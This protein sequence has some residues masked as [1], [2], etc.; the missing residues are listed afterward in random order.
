M[1][2]T[3]RYLISATP[4]PGSSLACVCFSITCLRSDLYMEIEL[5][6]QPLKSH[7][8]SMPQGS[9][10]P[11]K[12]ACESISTGFA[13]QSTNLTCFFQ[14]LLNSQKNKSWEAG[15]RQNWATNN[16]KCS[17][18]SNKLDQNTSNLI[19]SHSNHYR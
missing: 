12:K 3:I 13:C 16:S 1:S 14:Q 8:H 6:L 18:P 7:S 15:T 17:V 2:C 9:T 4:S 10:P 11:P 19:S 5:P